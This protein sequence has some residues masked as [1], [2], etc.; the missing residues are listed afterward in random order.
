MKLKYTFKG[1]DGK[2]RQVFIDNENKII[3]YKGY[4]KDYQ[5]KNKNEKR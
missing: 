3:A 4:A 5:V 2:E 1:Y